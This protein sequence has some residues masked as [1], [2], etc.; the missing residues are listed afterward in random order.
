MYNLFGRLALLGSTNGTSLC[1]SAA[2][3]A[4][5]SVDYILTVALRDSITGTL[6]STSTA[7]NALIV[8]YICHRS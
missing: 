6:V 5:V 1:T 7:H 2:I 8:N 3:S 4:G